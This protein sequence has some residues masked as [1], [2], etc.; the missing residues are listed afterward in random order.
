MDIHRIIYAKQIAMNAIWNT[1]YSARPPLSPS[2]QK[3]LT[4]MQH[5][6]KK[7]YTTG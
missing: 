6:M 2:P 5:L 4:A 3:L 7:E 1:V